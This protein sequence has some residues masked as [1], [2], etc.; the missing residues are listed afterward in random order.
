MK[1]IV[2]VC[3]LSSIVLVGCNDNYKTKPPESANPVTSKLTG[4]WQSP[5]YGETIRVDQENNIFVYRHIDEMCWLDDQLETVSNEQLNDLLKLGTNSFE[6]IDGYGTADFHAPGNKFTRVSTLPTSCLSDNLLDLEDLEL[7]NDEIFSLITKVYEQHYVDFSLHDVDWQTHTSALQATLDED[8]TIE[9]L[10]VKLEE[11]L[12]PLKDGHNAVTIGGNE[13]RIF[14]KDL[15]S[16]VFIK[17][18]VLDNSLEWPINS[19]EWTQV[20]QEQWEA[21]FSEQLQMIVSNITS[22]T[23]EDTNI[24]NLNDGLIWWYVE[25][26]I[27][28]INISAMTGYAEAPQD[29]INIVNETMQEV[30]QDNQNSEALIIDVRQNLGGSDFISLAIARFFTDSIIHGYSKQARLDNGFTE[31]TPVYIEPS[32]TGSFTKPIY[33]LTSNST[34]SAAEIFTLSMSEFEHVTIVG[35]RSQ[36]AFSDALEWNFNDELVIELSNERYLSKEE[37][38]YEGKGVPVDI[39]VNF[40]SKQNRIDGV[41]PGLEAVLSE[42]GL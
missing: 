13:V 11:L 1:S 16:T 14:N 37:I 26:N 6:L 18:F 30:I 29:A 23:S 22:L 25:D 41:D 7:S 31:L 39:M 38:W 3:L 34:V 10:H 36:G 28:Y 4:V 8:T 35:E 20:N 15:F 40:P 42:L 17:E 5:A 2:A 32:E 19:D 24:K 12:G 33:L 9:E 21:Y 27:G